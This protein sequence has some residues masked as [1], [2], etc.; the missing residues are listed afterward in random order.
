MTIFSQNGIGATAGPTLATCSPLIH[1][2]NVWFVDST[3]GTDA[4]APAGKD[5]NF[6]LA[7][8]Q[9][10]VTNSADGDIIVMLSTHAETI[11]TAIAL[12]KTLDIV[13]E[14]VTAAGLPSVVLTLGGTTANMFGGAG[15]RASIQNVRFAAPAAA[16]TGNYIDLSNLAANSRFDVAD[17]YFSM[18][19]NNGDYGIDTPAA[20]LSVNI[21]GSTFISTATALASRPLPAIRDR[22][23]GS[24]VIHD[25]VFDG[26]TYG[27]ATSGGEPYAIDANTSSATWRVTETDFIRG[28]DVLIGTA[29]DGYIA[30]TEASG[31]MRVVRSYGA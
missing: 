9:Q 2:G 15:L 28:A 23:T 19:G 5:R 20:A 13:G 18:S 10:A 25:S 21:T 26:G 27:F 6:P 11:S 4:V 31:S 12:S 16:S 29:V 14:G 24:V 17:C 30:V 22:T 8:L 7:T 1:G 3:T